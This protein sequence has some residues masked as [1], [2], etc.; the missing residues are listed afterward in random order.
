MST[1]QELW[2]PDLETGPFHIRP[3]TFVLPCH[4]FPVHRIKCTLG[5]ALKP[6][7]PHEQI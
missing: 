7:H 2:G 1:S 6:Q 3:H 4:K 5:E